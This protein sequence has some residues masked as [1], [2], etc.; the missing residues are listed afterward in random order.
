MQCEFL[1]EYSIRTAAGVETIRAGSVYFIHPFKAVHLL[2]AGRVRPVDYAD[3]KTL[4]YLDASGRRAELRPDPDQAEQ[5]EDHEP[6]EMMQV[7]YRLRESADRHKRHLY[8][9]AA[10]GSGL[11]DEEIERQAYTMFAEGLARYFVEQSNEVPPGHP[12]DY[13]PKGV[14]PCQ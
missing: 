7:V 6:D 11:T 3:I 14:T 8:D 10:S 5:Y 2:C 1:E 4:P 12:E 13:T 9:L